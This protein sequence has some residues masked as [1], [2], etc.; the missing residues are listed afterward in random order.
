MGTDGWR[1]S[2][3]TRCRASPE[4]GTVLPTGTQLGLGVRNAGTT[5][6]V[7]QGSLTETGNKLDVAVDGRGYF[8]V[9]LP[10]AYGLLAGYQIQ[11]LREEA[12]RR[13]R[14]GEAKP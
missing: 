12:K 2:P 8:G 13:L 11:S 1:R 14:P 3:D 6:I 5:R 9:L 10:S 7:T 4:T